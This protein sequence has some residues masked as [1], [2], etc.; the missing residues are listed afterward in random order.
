[1][2]DYLIFHNPA[3][4]TSRKALAEVR[5]RGIEPRIVEY[6]KTPPDASTLLAL[7]RQMGQP[8]RH[9]LREK[10]PL[11]AELG[12]HEDRWSDGALAQAMARHPVLINRPIV[13]T[14]LGARLCRPFEVVRDILPA[15]RGG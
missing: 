11:C 3:C 14:P 5:E 4:S 1:M 7:A 2:S 13:V 10:E 6:L 12:L 15:H 9:L 8:V